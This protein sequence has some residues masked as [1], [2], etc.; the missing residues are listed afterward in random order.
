VAT[1]ELKSDDIFITTLVD[2]WMT[3]KDQV[4][5]I[6]EDMNLDSL[7][8]TKLLNAAYVSVNTDVKVGDDVVSIKGPKDKPVNELAVTV[9][10]YLEDHGTDDETFVGLHTTIDRLLSEYKSRVDKYVE[11][12]KKEVSEADKLTEA[13]IAEKRDARKKLVDS[14]NGIRSLLEGTDANWWKDEGEAL[15][16]NADGARD[17]YENLRGAFGTRAPMGERLGAAFTYSVRDTEGQTTTA[18]TGKNLTDL[19]NFIKAD[20]VAELKKLI[21]EKNPGFIW[22]TPPDEFSFT[23]GKFEVHAT[24]NQDDSPEEDE[25][26][27]EMGDG[28]DIIMD[29]DDDEENTG[30]VF[31][32]DDE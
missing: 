27:P 14:M 29:V 23:F 18:L 17:K 8:K 31:D 26:I 19:K 21:E 25:P 30:E 15:L 22:K 7:G 3:Q 16:V 20:S 5:Q 2:K 4:E 28:P 12:N 11:D 10:Q 24:K 32:D 13:Q 9:R 6:D 1:Y